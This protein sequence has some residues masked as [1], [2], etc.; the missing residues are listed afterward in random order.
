LG[1]R[2]TGRPGEIAD[3]AKAGRIRNTLAVNVL[4]MNVV[5]EVSD[6]EDARGFDIGRFVSLVDLFFGGELP[7]AVHA[8][9]VDSRLV[10]RRR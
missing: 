3:R 7:A 4:E 6:R 8:R 1:A 2:R 5:V 10:S 9:C